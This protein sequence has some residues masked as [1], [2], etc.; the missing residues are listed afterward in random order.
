MALQPLKFQIHEL[1]LAAVFSDLER[2]LRSEAKS[3]PTLCDPKDCSTQGP[4]IHEISQA[5]ILEWVAI[6]S[7]RG[8]SQPQDQTHV[9]CIGKHILYHLA[10]WKRYS[11]EIK[12]ETLDKIG[13]TV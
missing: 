9:S 4:F 8:S 11:S 2:E 6:S 13:N 3:C 1:V 10:T 7:Y 12:Q 5:R